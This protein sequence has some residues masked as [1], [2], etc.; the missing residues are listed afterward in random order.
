[1]TKEPT[2]DRADHTD[3]LGM[4]ADAAAVGSAEQ[5]CRL[6]AAMDPRND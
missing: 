6:S 1:M 5:V 3:R 4:P 2:P